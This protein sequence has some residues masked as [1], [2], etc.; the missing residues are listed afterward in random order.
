MVRVMAF[1]TF[2][3]FHAGHLSFLWQAKKLGEELLV[4]VARDATVV[5]VKGRTPVQ[6]EQ[7]RLLQINLVEYVDRAI[8]GGYHDRY[9][10]IRQH[11]PKVI[12]LG[13]DQVAFTKSLARL[14]PRIR[15]VRAQPFYPERYKTSLRLGNGGK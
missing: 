15:I 11:Q 5:T 6:P 12:C 14:F 1:G 7:E 10:V 4:V 2:D 9:A 8:L 3:Q 13:Y